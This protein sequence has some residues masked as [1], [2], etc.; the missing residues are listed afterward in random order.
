LYV[1]IFFF[2]LLSS[3]VIP[4][5]A[6]FFFEFKVSLCAF[7]YVCVCVVVVHV[8]NSCSGHT[9]VYTCKSVYL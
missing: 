6:T 2:M 5:F 9:F 1:M 3:V 8:V 4:W 7:I